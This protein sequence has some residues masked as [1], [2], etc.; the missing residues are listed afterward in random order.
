MCVVLFSKSA[1]IGIEKSR[2]ASGGIEPLRFLVANGFEV[3][4]P[5]QQRSAAHRQLSYV[6]ITQSKL[7]SLIDYK[8]GVQLSSFW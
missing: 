6:T 7:D 8:G 1:N 3:R 2:R 5:H 4:P